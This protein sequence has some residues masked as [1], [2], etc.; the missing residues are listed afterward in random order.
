MY[1]EKKKQ[2][3]NINLKTW[4][5]SF[6]DGIKA[7]IAWFDIKWK[8]SEKISFLEKKWFIVSV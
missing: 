3:V 5:A 4:L 8:T 1:F 6:D 2:I 7:K